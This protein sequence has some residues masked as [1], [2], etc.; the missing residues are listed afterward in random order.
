ME[1]LRAS[2]RMS[3][4]KDVWHVV[5]KRN[6][7]LICQLPSDKLLLCITVTKNTVFGVIDTRKLYSLIQKEF[8]EVKMRPGPSLFH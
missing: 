3:G 5:C 4:N 2:V 6:S 7:M 1:S 8:T